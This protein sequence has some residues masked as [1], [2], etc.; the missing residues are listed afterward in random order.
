MKT[1]TF[2]AMIL[3]ILVS[4]GHLWRLF[5]GTSFIIGDYNVPQWV[6]GV[7]VIVTA[8]LATAI[9]REHR[10]QQINIPG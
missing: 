9:W 8:V 3:L 7:A 2:V 4:A 10:E 6:S 5:S 1:G